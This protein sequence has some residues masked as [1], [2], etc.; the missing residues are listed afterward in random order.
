MNEVIIKSIVAKDSLHKRIQEQIAAYFKEV[1]FQ[2]LIDLLEE[3]NINLREN[4]IG[5]AVAAA[6]RNRQIWYVDGVVIGKFSAAI[7][8][9]LRS[10]GATWDMR[11]KVFRLPLGQA[12]LELRQAI[13]ASVQATADLNKQVM[14]LLGQMQANAPKA[15]TGVDLKSSLDG[16]FVD[17]R[18]QY[19]KSLEQHGF[20]VPPDLNDTVKDDIAKEYTQNM[21][22]FIKD[23]TK[24]MIPELREK[25]QDNIFAGGRTDKLA[26]II[27]AEYGVTK[28]KAQFL[29][30][31]ET[32][33]LVSKYRQARYTDAGSRRYVWSTSK[34]R[35]VRD[36]HKDL[37]GKIFYWSSP[38]ITNRTTGARNHPGED[39]GCRCVA[40]PI[41]A[42]EEEED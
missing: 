10:M 18:K 16:V 34:D 21:D 1:I 38:P 20:A 23:F 42:L 14:D 41:V 13:A 24:K 36:D 17:L 39:F 35:R 3:N 15:G 6:L 40:R 32:S 30:E 4:A 31:Q 11:T 27:E 19:K 26:K 28:R 5:S 29:A 7:S 25:I 22:K 2:P 8:R 33:L 12:S 37:D 9:E